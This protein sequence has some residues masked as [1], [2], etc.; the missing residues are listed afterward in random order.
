MNEEVKLCKTIAITSPSPNLAVAR[1][2]GRI[3]EV[4][5]R[6]NGRFIRI[7]PVSAE[8]NL[9]RASQGEKRKLKNTKLIQKLD[10]IIRQ[11]EKGMTNKEVSEKFGV[12]KNTISTWMKNK[13][14]QVCL[15]GLKHLNI[16]VHDMINLLYYEY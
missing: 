8:R 12:P 10:K 16:L 13:D 11:M 2:N 15:S 5:T 6:S 3:V 7:K 14:K 4:H 1:S 9:N